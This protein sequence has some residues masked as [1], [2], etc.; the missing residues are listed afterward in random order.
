MMECACLLIAV[1]GA[2]GIL[3]LF[4]RLFPG[5][6]EATAR[7]ELSERLG[8]EHEGFGEDPGNYDGVEIQIHISVDPEIQ[9]A[10][11]LFAPVSTSWS[12]R[13]RATTS[14]RFSDRFE[15][16]AP[17]PRPSV[18]LQSSLMD[19]SR[20]T[21]VV[22]D[23]DGLHVHLRTTRVYWHGRGYDRLLA[24]I[25]KATRA[26]ERSNLPTA[27]QIRD[28]DAHPTYRARQLTHW[29]E[30]DPEAAAAVARELLP[31]SDEPLEVRVTLALAA[32]EHAH[33][34]ALLAAPEVDRAQLTD[35]ATKV[36]PTHPDEVVARLSARPAPW[37]SRLAAHVMPSSAEGRDALLGLLDR[38]A[39]DPDTAVEVARRLGE[40]P[41]SPASLVALRSLF[42][43]SEA[44]VATVAARGLAVHGAIEDVAP[45]KAR[46]RGEG[47]NTPLSEACASA[48]REIQARSGGTRGGVALASGEGGALGIA[49]PNRTPDA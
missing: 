6:S 38:C 21:T 46:G 31:A 30:Q 23:P 8:V 27:D 43:A 3:W 34:L 20:Q 40:C 5:T 29:M 19:L 15:I 48:V 9:A 11:E 7:A 37:A 12:M 4:T 22:V 47:R 24:G 36:G 16:L 33:I 49:E 45:L 35:L 2:V 25:A 32:G 41:G 18:D 39:D 13:S 28:P 14:R 1:A 42:A 26:L 10:V 17:G 44:R